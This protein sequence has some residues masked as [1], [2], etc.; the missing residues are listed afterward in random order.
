[1]LRDL[2]V[3]TESAAE[4]AAGDKDGA[5]PSGSSYRRFLAKV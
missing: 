1:M 2:E 3:L 5:R 4:V